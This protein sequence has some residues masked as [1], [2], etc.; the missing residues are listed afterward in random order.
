MVH[1]TPNGLVKAADRFH[2]HSSMGNAFS[3]TKQL[4][5]L[6]E[7]E[8]LVLPMIKAAS[9]AFP[10]QEPAFE[11]AKL[12]LRSQI[13]LARPALLLAEKLSAAHTAQAVSRPLVKP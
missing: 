1:Q 8:D 5:Y 2:N 12:A 7:T 10:L 4:S 13:S 3:I 9:R 6:R 11:N